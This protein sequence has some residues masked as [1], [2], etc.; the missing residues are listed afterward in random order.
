MFSHSLRRKDRSDR[1][2]RRPRLVPTA[3]V[4]NASTVASTA[5]TEIWGRVAT[6]DGVRYAMED[7]LG[8]T[9]KAINRKVGLKVTEPLRPGDPGNSGLAPVLHG[10]ARLH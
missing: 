1:L 3:I 4:D 10:S 9:A 8:L 6:N 5:S 2:S 7:G